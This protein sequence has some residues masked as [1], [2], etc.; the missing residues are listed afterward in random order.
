MTLTKNICTILKKDGEKQA[1][2]QA[3]TQRE[4]EREREKK[5]NPN[6]NKIK[7]NKTEKNKSS[8]LTID[9]Y[10]AGI[11]HRRS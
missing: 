9:M 1:D 6:Q 3:G 10:S 5:T 7:Q 4:R 11:L 8:M 2:R